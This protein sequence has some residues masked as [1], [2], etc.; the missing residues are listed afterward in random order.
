[1]EMSQM[2]KREYLEAVRIRYLNGTKVEKRKILDE[3][4]DTTGYHWKYEIDA[5]NRRRRQLVRVKSS[6]RKKKRGRKSRY[7]DKDFKQTL[8]R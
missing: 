2:A 4:C 7:K 5:L 3:L 1:M 8:K 6:A